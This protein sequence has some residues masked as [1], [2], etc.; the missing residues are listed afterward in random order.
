M[1]HGLANIKIVYSRI[2]LGQL[3]TLIH[4]VRTHEHEEKINTI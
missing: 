2:L 4:D 1:M 3:L